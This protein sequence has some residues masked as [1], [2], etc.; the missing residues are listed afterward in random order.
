ME[1]NKVEISKE[2]LAE[3][4]REKQRLTLLE[5]GGVDNWEWYWDS[6]NPDD[7]ITY[8]DIQNMS[9]DE[10]IEKYL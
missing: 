10:V 3:L 1:T 9:D 8:N 4:I 5:N 2:R 6:I 7:G